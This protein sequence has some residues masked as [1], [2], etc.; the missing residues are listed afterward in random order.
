M[1]ARHQ[2][3]V[4]IGGITSDSFFFFPS[5]KKISKNV[6]IFAF[7]SYHLQQDTALIKHTYH[8]LAM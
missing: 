5:F 3:T 2:N 4:D 1:V 8:N 7:S 6:Y